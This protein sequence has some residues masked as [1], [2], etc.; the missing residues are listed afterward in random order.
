MNIN[1]GWVPSF[2]VLQAERVHWGRQNFSIVFKT[3]VLGTVSTT[4]SLKLVEP[5]CAKTIAA[6]SSQG[7]QIGSRGD[8]LQFRRKIYW[9]REF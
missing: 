2:D 7:Q 9:K 1:G 4:A 3:C 6:A 8:L 5:R